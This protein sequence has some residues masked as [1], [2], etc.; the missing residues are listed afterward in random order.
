MLR[1]GIIGW[2]KRTGGSLDPKPVA[3]KESSKGGKKTEKK[4]IMKNH[5]VR[6]NE[7]SDEVVIAR[8]VFYSPS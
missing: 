7:I 4:M 5:L 6:M 8:Q 2:K 3:S 1:G